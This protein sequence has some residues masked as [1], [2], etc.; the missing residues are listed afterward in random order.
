MESEN[1]PVAIREW[2]APVFDIFS[3]QELNGADILNNSTLSMY[4]GAMNPE[5]AT[6][7]DELPE[8]ILI[9]DAF[10]RG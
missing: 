10:R 7:F 5:A 4:N 2:K 8:E 9:L 6:P 3:G 1:K